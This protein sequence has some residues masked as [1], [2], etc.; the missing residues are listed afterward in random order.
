MQVLLFVPPRW[1]IDPEGVN[2]LLFRYQEEVLAGDLNHRGRWERSVS[3][4]T[5]VG[6]EVLLAPWTG[7]AMHACERYFVVVGDLVGGK[8]IGD[9]DLYIAEDKLPDLMQ[10][11]TRTLKILKSKGKLH[12]LY[13]DGSGTG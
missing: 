10:N 6:G 7:D 4:A 9:A 3:N 2:S 12:R 11:W 5:V 8:G 13:W 1:K